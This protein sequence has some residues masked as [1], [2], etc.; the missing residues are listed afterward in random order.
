MTRITNSLHKTE[1]QIVSL[2]PGG[3]GVGRLPSGQVCFV[4][5][6]APEDKLIVRITS[7]KKDYARAEISEILEPGIARVMP[8]CPLFTRCGGCQWLHLSQHA[9]ITAKRSFLEPAFGGVSTP[10]DV[11]PSDKTLRYRRVCRL[12]WHPRGSRTGALGFAERRSH[13]VVPIQR[14][15]I[16]QDTL[17]AALDPLRELLSL[18]GQSAEVKLSG[19]S[20]PAVV[21]VKVQDFAPPAFYEAASRLVA[22]R[23]FSGV[24][25]DAAGTSATIAGADRITVDGGTSSPI[26]HAAASFGQANAEVNA[27]LIDTVRSWTSQNSWTSAVELFSGS[28]NLTFA[29]SENL[30]SLVCVE[31]DPHACLAAEQNAHRLGRE[32]VTVVNADALEGYRRRGAKKSLVVL[33]PPRTGA[34][35]LCREVARGAHDAV[36]YISC[37]P[38]TLLRDLAPLKEAGYKPRRARGFDM[39]PQTAHLEAAVLLEK[40][41]WKSS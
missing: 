27:Q 33:D 17:S 1:L 41:P 16:L 3:D 32:R 7:Q 25:L 34:F 30:A 38:A 13:R 4:P 12:H 29:L 39:F 36:L 15:P 35:E 37:N 20:A 9:Q 14:C 21:S 2:A 40:Q 6:S 28:G 23:A 31:L 24:L 26:E 8:Q 19:G 5:F 22:Q 10:W 11:V 18:L